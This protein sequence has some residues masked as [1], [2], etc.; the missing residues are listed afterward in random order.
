MHQITSGEY[1]L[2]PGEIVQTKANFVTS[3]NQEAHLKLHHIVTAIGMDGAERFLRHVEW[4][5]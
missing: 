4:N 2:G 5:R 3:Q 1:S